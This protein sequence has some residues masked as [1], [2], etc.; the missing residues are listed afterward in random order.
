M[1]PGVRDQPTFKRESKSTE[2]VPE[3][4]SEI[5]QDQYEKFTRHRSSPLIEF[6]AKKT[7]QD[8]NLRRIIMQRSRIPAEYDENK[9][10]STM[11]NE[12]LTRGRWARIFQ[13]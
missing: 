10:F 13:T 9:L 12:F 7:Q 8:I 5:D 2:K 1:Q 11:F 6:G 3:H 4:F